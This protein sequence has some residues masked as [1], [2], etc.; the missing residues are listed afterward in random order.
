MRGVQI[1]AVA[2]ALIAT[3]LLGIGLALPLRPTYSA[4]EKRA[5]ASFPTAT[6]ETLLS[7]AYF[8]DLATWFSDTFPC[9]ETLLSLGAKLESLYG[10]Q[11]ESFYGNRST[12]V[13]DTIPETAESLAPVMTLAAAEPEGAADEANA[14][15]SPSSL[16]HDKSATGALDQYAA[17]VETNAD[18]TL[19]EKKAEKAEVNGEQ[20]GS[21]Y[22]TNHRGYEIYYYNQGGAVKY[23]SMIN[24]Y[25]AR[26][27]KCEVYDILVPNSFG[28]ELDRSTQA[29]LG[30]SNMEDAFNYIYS[31]IDPEV[32]KVSVFETLL[33]HKNEYI[34]FHTD[35]HWTG[36]GAYYAYM[37]FCDA[38]GIEPHSLR[39][40]QKESFD[41]FYGTFY[42]STNRSEALKQ[43]PDTVEAWLPIATNEMEYINQL[44]EQGHAQVINDVTNSNAGDKY[45][46]FIHGDNPLTVIH[47]PHRSDGSACVLIKESYGNAFAPYL[48]DHYEDVYV[49]DYRHF[50][51]SIAQLIEEYGVQ[52]IIFLNNVMALSERASGMMMGLLG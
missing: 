51:G 19:K 44:G 23:A 28:V 49:V 29:A 6:T 10:P 4:S 36:L 12:A 45:S 52:D 5:L 7:G 11:G 25:R 3:V 1:V 16:A 17:L 27:P 9:R 40:Y 13:A 14:S 41:G 24:T 33:Q 39:D 46:A 50:E 32:H 43:N 8:T 37:R 26:F 22:V 18:G 42:F 35:H 34:Y 15:A 47:N 2:A 20:A 21:I 38:K 31:M 48:V 30:S